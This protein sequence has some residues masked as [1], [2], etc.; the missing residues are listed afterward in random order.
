MAVSITNLTASA[1]AADASSYNTASITPTSN[2]LVLLSVSTRTGISTTP[3]Q[4]TA[5]G[6]GLT[7]V[8]INSVVYDTESTSRRRLTLFRALGASPSTGAITVDFAGQTQT[9]MQWCVDQ[10]SGVDTSGTNG[11]GAI[12]Q[13]ATQ[14]IIESDPSA[15]TIVATLAA[16]GSSANGTY[17]CFANE[18]ISWTPVAGSGFTLLSDNNVAGTDGH[19]TEWRATN[20]T[21]VDITFGSQTGV[22][23]IGIEIRAEVIMFETFTGYINGGSGWF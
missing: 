9:Q 11:S 18:D 21:T 23:A 19:T 3:N 20:D 8:V 4:P 15:T 14:Q 7:W 6:C 12:V 16:F 5:S 22:G 13:S 17:G 2:N 10:A 1:D